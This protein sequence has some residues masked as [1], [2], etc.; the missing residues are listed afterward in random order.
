LQ[1]ARDEAR[2]GG[3][4]TALDLL[5]RASKAGEPDIEVLSLRAELLLATADP[6]APEAY[7]HAIKRARGPRR[8]LLQVGQVQAHIALGDMAAAMKKIAEV[9]PP[10]SDEPRLR[11]LLVRGSL[12]WMQGRL[13]VAEQTT[14]EAS[15]LAV[16]TGKHGELAES[17][18]T[19]GMVAHGN[20][21]WQEVL[22]SDLLTAR[23]PELAAAIHEGHLCAAEVYLY[24][25]Q[26]YEDIAT[27]AKDLRAEGERSGARRAVVFGT[28]LLGETAL[29]TGDLTTADSLLDEAATA[30]LEIGARGAAALSLQR[31][32][33]SAIAAGAPDRA[34]FLLAMALDQA[35]SSPLGQRH[36]LH[37]IYGTKVQ[38]AK[39]PAAALA[40]VDEAELAII[41]PT[42]S[43]WACL[44]TFCVPAAIACAPHDLARARRY[45]GSA[46]QMAKMFWRGGAWF[47]SVSEARGVIE[48]TEGKAEAARMSL[49]AAADLFA[50]AGHR[51]DSER[52]RKAALV[53]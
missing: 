52:C 30:S 36:M 23:A 34:R 39:D 32:A 27:F 4:A 28:C 41:G 19:R 44:I 6:R 25:G 49:N 13:E 24:G 21:N 16:K 35:R 46:E 48:R 51:L 20:G 31:R 53:R 22:R 9:Q 26:P 2:V 43:C 5:E 50:K 40:V 37:R 38:A 14:E 42:E 12:E 1:A 33:E 11:Y 15:A 29:L 3:F 18:L 8:E 17:M 7:D 45:L 47:A 10:Q